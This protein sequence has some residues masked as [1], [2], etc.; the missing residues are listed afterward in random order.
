MID[1]NSVTTVFAAPGSLGSRLAND[2][3]I[4]NAADV[5]SANNGA[6]T[7]LRVGGADLLG[8]LA[9]QA[10]QSYHTF[11][12]PARQQAAPGRSAQP[13]KANYLQ[14]SAFEIDRVSAAI[15]PLLLVKTMISAAMANGHIDP[16][17]CTRIV[18]DLERMR[19]SLEE[20]V[21]LLEQMKNPQTIPQLAEQVDSK[22]TAMEV[23]VAA[24][25]VTDNRQAD[26]LRY[27][28]RLAAYLE[29]PAALVDALQQCGQ[30]QDT[31]TAA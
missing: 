3:A 24:L 10:Y 13:R 29:L 23:Y 19:L 14:R 20:R 26:A 4:A 16:H 6:S 21:F 22:Q 31:A 18:G 25:L 28:D 30:A 12:S 15:A 11:K 7:Q 9:W 2:G 8:R 17:A 27:L 5:Q 1:V